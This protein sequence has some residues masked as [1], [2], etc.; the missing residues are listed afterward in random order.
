VLLDLPNWRLT[1]LSGQSNGVA[2][3]YVYLACP[4]RVCGSLPW[5]KRL[6]CR[7][8]SKRR[9]DTH[10]WLTVNDEA[11]NPAVRIV[12]I[13]TSI[14]GGAGIAAV[15]L[16]HA[17]LTQGLDSV[18]VTQGTEP[19]AQVVAVHR[20][21][22]ARFGQKVTTVANRL[23]DNRTGILFSP[24]S[25]GVLSLKEVLSLQ[26]DI[27]HIHNWYNFFDWQIAPLLEKQ[28]VRIVAT[29]HDERLL[30]GGCHY[31]LECPARTRG[32]STCP[33]ARVARI[34]DTSRRR[35]RLSDA[36]KSSKATLIAPSLWLKARADTSPL[37]DGIHCEWIPNC[38]DTRA[39]FPK[40]SGE[41]GHVRPSL[42][43]VLGKSPDLLALTL[44]EL[45]RSLTRN[46]PV[47]PIDLIV[48]G[49]GQAP[50]WGLGEIVEFGP[51]DDDYSRRAFWSRVDIGL[52]VTLADNFP[53]TILEGL[54][55]GVPQVVP[56]VGGADEA[57]QL[58]GGGFATQR[59]PEALAGA[60]VRLLGDGELRQRLGD[61]ARSG[62]EREY[63]LA[64][65]GIRHKML[66]DRLLSGP[67]LLYGPA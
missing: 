11:P 32:C 44:Q 34:V 13:A 1:N 23:V 67:P 66:Y 33:Q 17:L 58:T 48:A 22:V 60:V 2:A 27:V 54:A 42:G 37:I 15:R 25:R 57:V 49:S 52:F 53:N 26:P 24:F 9:K 20:S 55:C 4:S 28:G 62:S 12:H 43:F 6:A 65:I 3:L 46:P 19:N 5:A 18:L 59:T 51:I 38:I 47:G 56:S 31:A 61:L 41:P 36:L 8:G 45:E 7:R 39:L 30:T 63:S 16:H 10:W 35:R 29:M 64:Q 50:P 21:H 14:S 40:S